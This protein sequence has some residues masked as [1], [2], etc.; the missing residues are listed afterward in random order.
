MSKYDPELA[1]IKKTNSGENNTTV[2]DVPA[3]F[4]K[5][6]A[7]SGTRWQQFKASFQRKEDFTSNDLSAEEKAEIIHARTEGEKLNKGIKNRHMIMISMATGI[8]TGLL[9]GSGSSLHKGGP[10]G[11]VI[12]I[13]IVGAMLVNV[14]EAA[15][16]LAVT[17]GDLTGGFNA[18]TSILIDPSFAFAV[19][20]NYCIQWLCVMPLELVTA[21]MTI[22]YWTQINSD[23]WVCIFYVL[24]V[25]INMVGSSAYGEAEFI[26][27]TSKTLMIIGFIILTIVISVGGAGDH[28]YYGAKFW[29]HPGA[30]ANS[31]KGVCCVFVNSAFSLGC[32][33]MLAFSASEQANPRKAIP[34]ATKQVCYRIIFLFVIP[35]F[36]ISLLVPYNSPDLLGAS[37]AAK[38]HSSPFVI[39]V[40]SVKVVPHIVNFVILL[41]VLSV[42]N[43]ALFCASRT[44]QSLAEQGYAPK[45]FNYID[46][47]GRPF[48][49]LV[50]SSFIGLFSFIAA[51]DK[52]EQV[53]NWLL[54]ISGLSTIF[55]WT[56]IVLS[57]VRFRTA[58][59]VQGFAI[60]ELG[61]TAKTG[62][63]GS[64]FAIV[65]NVLIL[66][67]QFWIA[68]FPVDSDG[69]A[70]ANSFFQ[71]YLGA[72]VALV[73]YLGHKVYTRSWRI[74][75]PASEIDLVK[76][77]KLFDGDVLAQEA[78]EDAEMV[79]NSSLWYRTYRFWC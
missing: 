77:R 1:D 13:I 32:T 49:A 56:G 73:M 12:G 70:D 24:I 26:F 62:V 79:R 28:V 21:T 40:S 66:M 34:S 30:F 33:E 11:L 78:A 63:I 4:N 53:F 22:K 48:R 27:N 36:M 17:Y 31:F 29:H 54:S 16:E 39:A 47:A 75:I 71:N 35:L 67:A 7:N 65:I 50:F 60:S 23:A 9:V 64:Y 43:S 14:M 41:A 68:L 19:S 74:F 59:K 45:Y 61:Y 55:T 58:F 38:T 69:K 51:Y 6:N 72:V 76:G 8:G 5:N 18:Y 37:G 57:H 10:A 15:G 46:A 25:A 52:Q 42:G 20:W 44:L 3:D 2:L